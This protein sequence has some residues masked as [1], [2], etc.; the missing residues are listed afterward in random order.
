MVRLHAVTRSCRT[1]CLLPRPL[2]P[3]LNAE[4][5]TG[6]LGGLQRAAHGNG[7][8]C[9]RVGPKHGLSSPEAGHGLHFVTFSPAD[10]PVGLPFWAQLKLVSDDRAVRDCG[11]MP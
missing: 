8:K 2:K 7:R 4:S 3:K 5:A 11:S 9:S 1:G 6:S 10:P